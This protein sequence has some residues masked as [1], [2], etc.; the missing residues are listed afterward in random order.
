MIHVVDTFSEGLSGIGKTEIVSFDAEGVD[1]S[2]KGKI[3]IVQIAVPDSCFIIDV[4]DKS[5]DDPLIVWLRTLLESPSVVKV[6]HDCRM[7]SD[8]LFHHLGIKLTNV[9]DSSCWHTAITGVADQNLN[10]VLLH[11]GLRPNS[12]RD[13]S[14][15]ERNPAFWA[16]RPLTEKMIQWASGDVQSMFELHDLQKKNASS[17]DA[18]LGSEES[19]KYLAWRS[20]QVSTIKVRNPGKFIGRGG[21]GIRNLQKSSGTLI[22]GIGRR[23]DCTFMVFFSSPAS[24]AA[25]QR[26]AS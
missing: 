18:R 24:L 26:A 11:N 3:S 22:Y 5:P 14:V 12:V 17:R 7:D 4:L 20:A 2:R 19:E 8:A 6:V 23:S 25:V 13:N 21:T 10:T 9:H 1:L 16:V 15:Y